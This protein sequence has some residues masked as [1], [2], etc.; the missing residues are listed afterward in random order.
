MLY[1]S[2][3]I[4]EGSNISNATI[5]SG[6]SYPSN[7]SVGELFYRTD[8][9]S[10]GLF[11]YSGSDWQAV[12]SGGTVSFDSLN[13]KAAVKLATTANITLSGAQTID[14]ESAIAADRV[15]VKNQTTASQN[16]IYVVASGSWTRATDFDGS[17]STE[18]RA[19]DFTFVTNGTTQA[20]TGWVL[21][22]NGT[23]TIGT[24]GLT[25]SLFTSGVVTAA[26]SSG[27]LQFNSGGSFTG[28]TGATYNAGTQVLTLA[29]LP[30]HSSTKLGYLSIPRVTSFEVSAVG[31]RVA[32]TSNIT[33]NPNVF[34]AGDAVSIYNASDVNIDITQGVSMTLRL[35]GTTVTGTRTLFPRGT[36][37]IWF[38]TASEAIVSGSVS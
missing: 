31:K 19:G 7:P 23:I 28:A 24:T 30:L 35:D 37:L 21:T 18:V 8:A 25:F 10:D 9:P 29:E 27:E 38:D 6:T 3:N 32:L 5:A 16:G 1:D 11:V 22:T 13:V 26:G 20:D 15:L 4:A 17:P 33:V 14:G 12:G 34:A 36:C 2:I